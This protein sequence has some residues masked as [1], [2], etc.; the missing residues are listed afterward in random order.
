MVCLGNICRSP[1]AHGVL[2]KLIKDKRLDD[3]LEVDS[4][5]TVISIYQKR[6]TAEQP[7]LPL[8]EGMT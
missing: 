2:D 5:G 1:T 7:R 6:Q 8:P 3:R 4:A